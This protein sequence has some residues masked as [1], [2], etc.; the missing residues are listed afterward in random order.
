[1]A[2]CRKCWTQYAEGHFPEECPHIEGPW[3]IVNGVPVSVEICDCENCKGIV[4]RP[5]QIG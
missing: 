2:F 5:R 4:A 3:A 1:V